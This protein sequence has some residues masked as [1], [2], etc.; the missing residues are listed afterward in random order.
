MTQSAQTCP[1]LDHC[2][3]CGWYVGVILTAAFVLGAFALTTILFRAIGKHVVKLLAVCI[4]CHVTCRHTFATTGGYRA[5][6][7]SKM[8]LQQ[9]IYTAT[10]KEDG[11]ES[12]KYDAAVDHVLLDL[13]I[14]CGMNIDHLQATS[15]YWR[16]SQVAAGEQAGQATPEQSSSRATQTPTKDAPEQQ[17]QATE[18]MVPLGCC[19]ILWDSC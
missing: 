18:T 7:M 19:S 8:Q 4:P 14:M 3:Q 12:E 10:V 17:Q 5:A 15:R 16:Q 9:E 13:S 11:A 1:L 2:A 6:N